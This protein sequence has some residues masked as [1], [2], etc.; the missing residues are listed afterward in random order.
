MS[1]VTYHVGTKEY[2]FDS[3]LQLKEIPFIAV[4]ENLNHE[5]KLDIHKRNIPQQKVHS[6]SIV[7]DNGLKAHVK[8]F[9]EIDTLK[10]ENHETGQN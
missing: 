1:K 8:D 7:D 2:T 5:I 3:N 6:I 4:E 9:T 10:E